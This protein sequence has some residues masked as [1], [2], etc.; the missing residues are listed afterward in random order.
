[1]TYTRRTACCR[2]PTGEEERLQGTPKTTVGTPWLHQYAGGA[3][4]C[5][6]RL[7]VRR[8]GLSAQGE[9]AKKTEVNECQCLTPLKAGS[10]EEGQWAYE[11]LLW[12]AF[13]K[14]EGT[15]FGLLRGEPGLLRKIWGYV[16]APVYRQM[17]GREGSFYNGQ[18]LGGKQHGKGKETDS[19]FGDVYEGDFME[20]KRHGRGKMTLVDGDVYEGDWEQG[21]GHGK[22]KCSSADGDVYE[23]D[24][25][26]GKWHG[27]GKYSSADGH[28]EEGGWVCGR[29]LDD[30]DEFDTP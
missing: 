17:P 2:Y 3:S 28:V 4:P 14:Q 21:K 7:W 5:I 18:V 24:W 20:D 22:G 29:N 8:G 11:R 6:G 25:K 13:F 16:M 9:A 15:G 30:F 12:V 23:G 27:R 26:E 1:M 19:F 10:A